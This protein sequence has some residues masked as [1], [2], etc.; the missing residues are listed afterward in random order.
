MSNQYKK[1]KKENIKDIWKN[2]VG[3]IIDTEDTYILFLK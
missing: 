3:I 1:K 2:N